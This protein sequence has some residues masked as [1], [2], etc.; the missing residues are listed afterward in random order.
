MT[1]ANASNGCDRP[2]VTRTGYCQW[3]KEQRRHGRSMDVRLRTEHPGWAENPGMYGPMKHCPLCGRLVVESALYDYG[4][5]F[6]PTCVRCAI[7]IHE[8][9]EALT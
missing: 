6:K 8:L 9:E 3:C 1:C 7:G 4:E 2:A 5:G